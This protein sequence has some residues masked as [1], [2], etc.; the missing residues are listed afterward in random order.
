MTD[1]GPDLPEPNIERIGARRLPSLVWLVPILAVL[2]AVWLLYQNLANRGPLITISFATASGLKAGESVVKYR[3]VTV[4]RVEVIRFSEDLKTVLADVR[5]DRTVAPYLDESAK[6][7]VVRPQVS[8]QGVT[9][10]ET[11]ISGTYIEG[12]W[13][14]EPGIV[15]QAFVADDRPPPTPDGTPGVRIRLIAVDGGSLEIGSP[16]MFKRFEVG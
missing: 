11:V 9:G 12:T 4:G 16:I 1:S 14:T 7:W 10:L 3:D 8:A 6:F 13:D 5:M 15:R 2:G